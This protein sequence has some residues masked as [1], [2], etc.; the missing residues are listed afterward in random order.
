LTADSTQVLIIG[1][2]PAG[3]AAASTLAAAG[4]STLVLERQSYPR[5]KTCGDVVDPAGVHE[6]SLLGFDLAALPGTCALTRMRTHHEDRH[7]DRAWPTGPS[8]HSV[9]YSIRRE[10]LDHALILHAQNLGAQVLT[11]HE[12]IAPIVERGFVRGARVQ[13]SDG[14]VAEFPARFTLVADG[15]NSRFGRALGT[16]RNRDWPYATSIRGYWAPHPTAA[17]TPIGDAQCAGDTV[18]LHLDLT[19]TDGRPLLGYG[20]AV[21]LSDNSFNIG[22]TVISTSHGFRSINTT[23]LLASLAERVADRLGIDPRTPLAAPVSGRIPLGGSVGPSGG[24]THLVAGDAAGAANALT[25]A[26]IEYAL[27]TGRI[28]GEVLAQAFESD[29]VT[30]LQSY[31]GL[32]TQRFASTSRRG[33]LMTQLCAHPR[34]L[35]PTA[36]YLVGS[37]RLSDRVWDYALNGAARQWA[38]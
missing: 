31:P 2:G 17:E 12:A 38:T 22:V 4:I 18:D 14:T 29:D 20:W 6:L 11:G 28:A 27:A 1:G 19:G 26:G 32:L 21:P 30:V 10:I 8:G 24:P 13:R 5:P 33:R 36:R 23:A 3:A 16:Y 7:G 15:A 37:S 35:R 25:G 34:I 9:A